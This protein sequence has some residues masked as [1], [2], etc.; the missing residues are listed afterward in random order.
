[1]DYIEGG[2]PGSNPKDMEFFERAQHEL[3]L[4]HARVAAFGSTVRAAHAS[5]RTTPKCNS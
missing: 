2:W 5:R 4:K 1:M 3:H